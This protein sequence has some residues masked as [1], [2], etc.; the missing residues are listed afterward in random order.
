MVHV[1]HEFS[2]AILCVLAIFV[3]LEIFA[4]GKTFFTKPMHLIDFVIIVVALVAENIRS[5]ERVLIFF[6]MAWRVL[7]V[8]HAVVATVHFHRKSTRRAK[9]KAAAKEAAKFDGERSRLQRLVRA[10][11]TGHT[12][13]R[14]G[15]RPHS[16]PLP[17]SVGSVGSGQQKGRPRSSSRTPN[18]NEFPT[19]QSSSFGEAKHAHGSHGSQ[20]SGDG[21]HL[22]LPHLP[23]LHMP[24]LHMPHLPHLPHFENL[25]MPHLPHLPH[26]HMPNLHLPHFESPFHQHHHVQPGE[27]ESRYEVLSTSRRSG[28]DDDLDSPRRSATGSASVPGMRRGSKHAAEGR[29]AVT[30]STTAHAARLAAVHGGTHAELATRLQTTLNESAAVKK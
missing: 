24:H 14:A 16:M 18:W 10:S 28:Y 1:L 22:H 3:L 19:F 26:P 30:I 4:V 9:S 2:I 25:H 21:H 8:V 17:G 29:P 15:G 11:M 7:R 5:D 13:R 12:A 27:G 23:H 20:H 6:L